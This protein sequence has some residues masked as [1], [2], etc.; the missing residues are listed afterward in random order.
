[1]TAGYTWTVKKT[2]LPVNGTYLTPTNANYAVTNDEY[3]QIVKMPV[4]VRTQA[5][6][7]LT[8]LN[9]PPRPR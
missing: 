5:G 9:S 1:M 2:G 6:L 7:Q 4:R 3:E 8:I